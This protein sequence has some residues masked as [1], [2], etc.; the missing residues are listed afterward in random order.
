M[1]T[2]VSALAEH[3]R[4]PSPGS[5]TGRRARAERG[6]ARR[7][8]RRRL[9][10][11]G[12]RGARGA[13]HRPHR[14]RAPRAGRGGR[15]RRGHAGAGRRPPA[16]VR[17][18]HDRQVV[19]GDRRR[20][21]LRRR[22]G[23]RRGDRGR[24][25]AHRA[26]LGADRPRRDPAG[27][28]ADDRVPSDH[29]RVDAVALLR[30]AS[31]TGPTRRPTSCAERGTVDERVG[32]RRD[33][34][35]GWVAA[36]SAASH[37]ELLE[38]EHESEPFTGELR[39]YQRRGLGWMRFLARLGLGGCLADDM[40]LGKTATTLAHLVERPGRHLVVCPLSV[41]HNWE[42]ESARFTPSL[43][44]P[45][46]TAPT[47]RRRRPGRCS[48]SADADAR[49]HHLRPARPRHRAPVHDRMG[50]GRARRGAVREEPDHQGGPS[51]APPARR[52]SGS[53][54]PARR[55]RTGCPS[56][57][58]SSTASTPGC[59][60][61]QKKFRHRSRSR[62]S[63]DDP[64]A[65]AADAPA[66]ADPAVRAAAHEGR[67]ELVPD[68]PDKIEQIAYAG[69]TR[70]QALLYQ[71]VVDELLEDARRAQRDEAARADPG[72]ARRS[73]SRSATT[74]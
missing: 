44:S 74:R 57:G 4:Q 73:S 47:R 35:A 60:A 72:R 8:L 63:G 70:E 12:P 45:S 39:H 62:S 67:P 14:T 42:T 33:G 16:A 46:T 20:P 22:A 28:Q 71:K 49:H 55:S 2:V 30:L 64:T 41:V 61:A 48:V 27:P 29:A 50:H 59:S 26:P 52:R 58:R 69:L 66:H 17:R 11:H 53:R 19:D 5:P 24:A 25:A 9:P 37:D 3:R 31:G 6:R 40:G 38:E 32:E 43:R 1:E 18:R 21:D 13:R 7:R 36:C 15:S 56:C 54:S 34:T 23:P 68:L 65:A 51:R 10:R